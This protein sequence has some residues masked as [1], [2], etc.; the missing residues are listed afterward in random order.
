L[1]GVCLPAW[2][3]FFPPFRCSAGLMHG[4]QRHYGFRLL[5]FPA[6]PYQRT[7]LFCFF[8]PLRDPLRLPWRTI[9]YLSISPTLFLAVS[10]VLFSFSPLFSPFQPCHWKTNA[11]LFGRTPL[12][13]LA[14]S[15]VRGSPFR[16]P[17]SYHFTPSP[18]AL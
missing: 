3:F 9:S 1:G 17:T 16:H 14:C 4:L 7:P 6:G 11:P 13:R 2:V 5:K 15:F 12:V 10:P 18:L 8:G